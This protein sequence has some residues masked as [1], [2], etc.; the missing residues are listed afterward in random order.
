MHMWKH[1]PQCI[2]S[3]DVSKHVPWHIIRGNMQ[4]IAIMHV[5]PAHDCPGAQACVHDPQ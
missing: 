2:G 3:V 5:P 1:E 4:P